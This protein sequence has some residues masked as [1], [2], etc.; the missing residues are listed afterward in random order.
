MNSRHVFMSSG[1]ATTAGAPPSSFRVPAKRGLYTLSIR[2]CAIPSPLRGGLGWG[3][4]R[5]S[6][7]SV[8]LTPPPPTPP[9]KGEESSARRFPHRHSGAAQRGPA[10]VSIWPRAI[11]SPLRGGLGW[12]CRRI[13]SM[14]V[15]LTP[16]PPT[17]PR[18]GEESSARC[19]PPS[20]FRGREAEPGNGV[21]R[22]GAGTERP[23]DP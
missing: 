18:K 4:R 2:P 11:P 13:S 15:T 5:I 17:P 20:S 3:C 16:P 21:D 9:R 12:G 7:M 23:D 10:T 6:S 19:L 1:L 22:A 14:S 8:T